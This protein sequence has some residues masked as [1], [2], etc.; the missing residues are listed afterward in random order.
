MTE[1][2]DTGQKNE[3]GSAKMGKKMRDGAIE[4]IDSHTVRMHLSRA[5]LAMPGIHPSSSS[6]SSAA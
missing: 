4:K 2:Y 5:E 3:D 1:E 6:S